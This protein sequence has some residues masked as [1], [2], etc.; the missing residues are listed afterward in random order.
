MEYRAVADP[1]QVY[2]ERVQGN[3]AIYLDTNAWSDLTEGTTSDAQN[4]LSLARAARSRAIAI[5]PLGFAT[6][7]ELLKR[8]INADS[9]V[10]AE[11]MDILS[12]G[13]AF[14]GNTRIADEE[15]RSA[16]AFLLNGNAASP[17]E[18]VFTITPCYLSDTRV[19]FPDGWSED[20]ADKFMQKLDEYGFPGMRWLQQYMREQTHLDLQASTD[21]KYV[22]EISRKRAD[23]MTWA[24]DKSGKLNAAKVRAE[25]HA[26]V[27][28]KYILTRAMRVVGPRTVASLAPILMQLQKDGRKLAAAVAAM[29][30]TWLSCEM[31]VQRMLA[32]SRQTRK[33]D[34]Y[35]HEHAVLAVPYTQAFV[36]SDGGILDILRRVRATE[37]FDCRLLRGIGALGSY[38]S[39]ILTT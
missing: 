32:I 39:E 14:R 3:V 6:I 8:E 34:F 12:A 26:C 16:C 27:L 7:T 38:L 17:V 22:R 11:L 35:D 5:F 13:V 20:E 19:V 36:T 18:R 1:A 30:S 29:P 10:Q 31:N 33:Q 23:A 25:E 4:A 24:A 15:V 2:R 37:R 9:I 28:E 21:E